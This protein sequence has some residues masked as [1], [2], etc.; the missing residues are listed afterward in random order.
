M[1]RICWWLVDVLSRTLEPNE[2]D[3]IRGDL[4][5]SGETCGQALRDVLGLVL[6]RQ[7]A[8]WQDWRPWLALA[9]IVGVASVFLGSFSGRLGDQ[10]ILRFT[11]YYYDGSPYLSGLSTLEDSV[12]LA[13]QCLALVSWSWASGFVLGYLSRR[14]VWMTGSLFCLLWLRPTLT[15]LVLASLGLLRGPWYSPGLLTAELGAH[16]VFLLP[17]AWGLY[18]GVHARV[19]RIDFSI[20]IA[21]EITVVTA[22][23]LW[24]RHWW[25][26]AMEAWS[27]GAIRENGLDAH[28]WLAVAVFCWPVAYMVAEASWQRWRGGTV[29]G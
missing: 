14:T 10:L 15:L 1:S 3:A 8:P 5:E 7:A 20:V 24:T 11:V 2:Q 9:G 21:T 22:L 28:A 26:A 6:R 16:T 18:Q 23:S 29:A 17:Y 12:A 27:K 19:L 13:C 25:D 4:M